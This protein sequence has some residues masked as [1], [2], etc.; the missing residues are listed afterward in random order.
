M[1]VSDV[2]IGFSAFS[3]LGNFSAVIGSAGAASL[4]SSS[5]PFFADAANVAGAGFVGD[6]DVEAVDLDGCES[7]LAVISVESG[8][9][10]NATTI[11][12][13]RPV[14]HELVL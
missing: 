9:Q 14:I 6:L 8:E 2:Y 1:L 13:N 10:P 3:G 4:D 12:I 7:D 5:T 11:K